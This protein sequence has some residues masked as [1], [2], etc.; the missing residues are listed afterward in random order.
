MLL[1]EEGASLPTDDHPKQG[2][3]QVLYLVMFLTLSVL[4]LRLAYLQ[5]VKGESFHSDASTTTFAKLPVLPSRGRIYDAQHHLL[6]Y[7]Q[8]SFSLVLTRFNS[9]RQNYAAMARQIAPLFH[10]SAAHL[11]D[12]ME[13]KDPGSTQV[14]ILQNATPEQVTYIV[15]HQSSLPGLRIIEDPKRA[16]RYGSL[17]GH[18]IGYVHP[19]P[20]AE[21]KTYADKGYL[22]DEWVGIDGVE[23]SY[24]S[25]LHGHLGE[26]VLTLNG[27]GVPKSD[28]GLDP[29]P[30]AGNNVELTLDG[31]LQATAQEIVVDELRHVKAKY[32]YNPRDAEAVLLDVRTGGVLSMVSYPYYNPSWYNSGKSYEVHAA[33]LNGSLTPMINHVLQ[34]PRAPG[35]TVKPVNVLVGLQHGVIT[36]DTRIHD[37]G[38]EVVGE[39]KMMDWQ[40]R[41]HGVVGPVGAIA[42]SCDTFM[43]DMGMWLAHWHDGPP[44]GESV[45]RWIVYDRI[46]ALNWLFDAEAV[47]GLGPLTGID[48]PYEVSGRLYDNLRQYSVAHAKEELNREGYYYDKGTL[49]DVAAAAIGQNQQFTPMQ[50]A[51]YALTLANRGVRLRPHV[52]HRVIASD[53]HVKRTLERVELGRVPFRA[54]YI[55]LVRQG[56]WATTNRPGG[57]AYRA[58]RGAPYEA[59]GKTGTAQ[60]ERDRDISLFIGYAP[61]DHPQVC[62]AVMVPG[63]GESGETAVPIAR[64][65]FDAYFQEHHEYFAPSEWTDTDIPDVWKTDRVL[66]S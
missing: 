13:H 27:F 55:N 42:E 31:H 1:R 34:S 38:Y 43:Y 45:G 50:L 58:F 41:G 36:P 19:V 28:L 54:D 26:R 48:L 37:H 56:M 46:R 4:V 11:E 66:L 62:V 59:A 24:E 5:I 15:E 44:Q 14:R 10:T 65:L 18:V 22:L 16:Y 49:Y 6:A 7:D 30:V 63:G 32:H 17:A 9:K 23:R 52:L 47:F 57:T 2:R 64:K 40:P 8:P 12:L 53:G 3:I 25:V 29:P 60:I 20:A 35:S 33:Y 21:A 51:D 39:S 61:A